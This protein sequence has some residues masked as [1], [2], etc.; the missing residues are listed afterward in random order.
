MAY[1]SLELDG[2]CDAD[3]LISDSSM[4]FDILGFDLFKQYNGAGDG[5]KDA[6]LVVYQGVVE[7]SFVARRGSIRATNC[8]SVLVGG[9]INLIRLTTVDHLRIGDPDNCG[10]ICILLNRLLRI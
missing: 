2:G 10:I 6:N 4:G 3:L 1:N 9:N 8:S 5:D 7:V